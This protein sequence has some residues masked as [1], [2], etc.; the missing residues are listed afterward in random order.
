MCRMVKMLKSNGSQQVT[1]LLFLQ[2]SVDSLVEA[3]NHT[4]MSLQGKFVF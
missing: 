3:Y 1:R 4:A 2:A